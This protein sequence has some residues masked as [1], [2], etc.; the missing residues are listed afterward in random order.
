MFYLQAAANWA[1]AYIHAQTGSRETLNLSDLSGLAHFEL[2]R[3][4]AIAKNRSGLAVSQVELLG[5]LQMVLD[6]AVAQASKDP[7]G[8]GVAWGNGDTPA[9]GAGL[10][11]MASEYDYLTHSERYVA[12]ARGWMG[13]ILGANAWGS[14]FIVGDGTT[15]PQCIHH[16]L[17]NLVGS[18]NGQP[19]VLA[20]ALVEGPI[21][22]ADSGAPAG[23]L[24][25]PPDGTDAFS[26]FNGN[27]AVY[28]DNI[29]YYSTVEPAIDLTAPS[30]LMFAWRAAMAPVEAA[31]SPTG[32]SALRSK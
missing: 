7:F 17:A 15:F 31:L 24:K 23:S 13:N 29:E 21:R 28:R 20:G 1:S 25:C 4:I 8:Y 27:D 3:A 26:R 12:F 6:G 10:S 5:D 14:S 30:F 32:N 19:P 22:K 2:Y 9:H 11:V 16:Q 18:K